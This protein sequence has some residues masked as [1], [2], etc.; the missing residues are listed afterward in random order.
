[1]SIA[2]IAEKHIRMSLVKEPA[3]HNLIQQ[4]ELVRSTELIVH[5]QALFERNEKLRILVVID[6][7]DRPIGFVL[8]ERFYERMGTRFA[9]ALFNLKPIQRLME[10]NVLVLPY[11]MEASALL[12]LTTARN[13]EYMYDPV[14]FEHEGRFAGLMTSKAI[15]EL[16]KDIRIQ[17]QVREEEAIQSAC[18]SLS[19]IREQADLVQTESTLGLRHADEMM[20]ETMK[21]KG[22]LS[23]VVTSVETMTSRVNDQ[24][25]QM[26][27]L[28][29]HTDAAVNAALII[30]EWSETCQVLALNASIEAARAGEHG[31]GF[32]VVAAEVRKLALLTKAATEQIEETLAAMK[33]SLEATMT[34]S[35][36]SFKEA[37]NTQQDISATIT[38]LEQLFT[39]ISDNRERLQQVHTSATMMS[40]S[41]RQAYDELH[42]EHYN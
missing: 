25:Q 9:P 15:T 16:S 5:V 12:D 14:L 19:T 36:A 31:R 18:D 8:R 24:K 6:Q 20:K 32:E 17:H 26:D 42:M 41:A 28:S 29:Q 21:T 34:G 10:S 1:M 7:E 11:G 35:E 23:Q 30:R 38:Q 37:H 3:Y 39:A 33:Q 40:Q 13:E 27:I 4:A 22:V 2:A